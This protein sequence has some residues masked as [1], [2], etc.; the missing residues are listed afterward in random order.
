MI[1]EGLQWLGRAHPD[2]AAWLAELPDVLA[3]CASS[4]GR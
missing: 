2:G 3:E 1:P 4:G